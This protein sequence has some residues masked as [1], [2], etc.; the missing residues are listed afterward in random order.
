MLKMKKDST[1]RDFMR[2]FYVELIR[3]LDQSDPPNKQDKSH[4]PPFSHAK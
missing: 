3:F 4:Q 2:Y 1:E